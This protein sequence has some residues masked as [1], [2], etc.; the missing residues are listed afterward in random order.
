MCASDPHPHKTAKLTLLRSPMN[1]PNR[2]EVT[3]RQTS[4]VATKIAHRRVS[5]N[6][7]VGNST[8]HAERLWWDDNRI[9]NMVVVAVDLGDSFM[10]SI[11]DLSFGSEIVALDQQKPRQPT[12]ITRRDSATR[13]PIPRPTES[14][15]RTSQP[16]GESRSKISAFATETQQSTKLPRDSACLQHPMRRRRRRTPQRACSD[17][18]PTSPRPTEGKRTR[19]WTGHRERAPARSDGRNPSGIPAAKATTAASSTAASRALRSPLAPDRS[20]S[21]CSER[22]AMEEQEAE[23]VRYALELSLQ[24][25]SSSDVVS[26]QANKPPHR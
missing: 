23:L 7:Q 3:K 8:D 15:N 16:C 26:D 11:G 4:S 6:Q 24:D 20:F 5:D 22:V 12:A 14:A 17:P 25:L 1:K 21:S 13:A 2:S 9:E 18:C 10:S 19:S